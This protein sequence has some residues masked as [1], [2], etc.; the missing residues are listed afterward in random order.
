MALGYTLNRSF[1]MAKEKKGPVKSKTP[2]DTGILTE[3]DRA[4]LSAEAKKSVAAEMEQD[5]RDAYFASEMEKARRA[6]TPDDQILN[7]TID[8][9]PY[10]PFIMIDHFQYFHGYTYPVPRNRAV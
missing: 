8:V 4:A 1:K 10:V 3:A 5:A 6:N 2:V 9:A 7:V